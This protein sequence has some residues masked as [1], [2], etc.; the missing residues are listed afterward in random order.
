MKSH[1][2]HLYL[3]LSSPK[4]SKKDMHCQNG[5]LAFGIS[6]LR[7]SDFDNGN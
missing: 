5:N 3:I 1:Y 2:C 4:N 6:V 7:L